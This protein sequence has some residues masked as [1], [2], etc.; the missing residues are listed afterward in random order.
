MKR[1]IG[2]LYKFA[3]C[4]LFFFAH[5]CLDVERPQKTVMKYTSYF[6]KLRKFINEYR[7]KLNYD[8]QT[9][10]ESGG[11]VDYFLNTDEESALSSERYGGSL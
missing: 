2:E 7:M 5:G 1:A 6:E 3:Y 8:C 9:S 4:F 11:L 10:G